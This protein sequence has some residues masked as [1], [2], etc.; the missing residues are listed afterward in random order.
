MRGAYGPDYWRGVR[1][2]H[3]P[4][5]QERKRKRATATDRTDDSEAPSRAT[6]AAAASDTITHHEAG[7]SDNGPA[8]TT[9][10]AHDARAEHARANATTTAPNREASTRPR[11]RASSKRK[12]STIDEHDQPERKQRAR[13]AHPHQ[14]HATDQAHRSFIP[15]QGEPR[16]QHRPDHD[17]SSALSSADRTTAPPCAH[18]ATACH[19]PTAQPTP[20]VASLSQHQRRPKDPGKNSRK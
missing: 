13:S 18:G 2:V 9:P 12:A 3:D 1:A 8:A 10:H 16:D 7:T 15:T 14:A 11:P 6:N 4:T 20:S 17:A 19:A 5:P